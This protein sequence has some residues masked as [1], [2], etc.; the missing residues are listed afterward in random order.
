MEIWFTKRPQSVVWSFNHFTDYW[1]LAQ[2]ET[3]L[4]HAHEY[5]TIEAHIEAIVGESLMTSPEM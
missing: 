3:Q 4:K 1:L 5:F 2:G